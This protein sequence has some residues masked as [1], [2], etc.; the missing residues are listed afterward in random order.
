MRGRGWEGQI[1]N[2]LSHLK[3]PGGSSKEF[4]T[5]GISIVGELWE[6]GGCL[7]GVRE[8][9]G[10]GVGVGELWNGSGRAVGWEWNARS[11]R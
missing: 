7:G 3:G 11:T 10:R 5:R 4:L 9:S 8:S 2:N 6:R 1:L